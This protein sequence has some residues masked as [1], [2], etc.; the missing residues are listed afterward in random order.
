MRFNKKTEY[1]I[2]ILIYV[3]YST[4]SGGSVTASQIHDATGIPYKY[5]TV[6]LS[7]LRRAR[8]LKANRGFRGGYMLGVEPN[9]ITL[10]DITRDT[11]RTFLKEKSMRDNS[12]LNFSRTI[13]EEIID[14]YEQILKNIDFNTIFKR[15]EISVSPMTPMFYI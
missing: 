3:Y 13:S 6:I 8:I 15:Y 10:L 12:Y 1:A 7:E 9:K 11:S 14:T 2:A 5:L 4:K